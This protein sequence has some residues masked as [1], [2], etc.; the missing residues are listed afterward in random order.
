MTGKLVDAEVTW[1]RGLFYR[2]FEKFLLIERDN[3]LSGV[4]ERNL[5]HRLGIYLEDERRAY[6][7]EEYF[8]DAEYNR[9]QNGQLK[10][11]IDQEY[12]VVKITCDLILHSRGLAPHDNLIAIE[13]KKSGRPNPQMEKDRVRL[14]A[15]TR[16]THNDVWSIDG[17]AHPEHVC[18]YQFGAFIK[19]NIRRGVITV[20]EFEVGQVVVQREFE[21]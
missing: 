15:L 20:E 19:L 21:L 9:K 2:A 18:G 11:I 5:C 10:T 6:G 4:S 14:M 12:H 13:M 3:I 16:Q 17:R 8:V 1:M 7:L